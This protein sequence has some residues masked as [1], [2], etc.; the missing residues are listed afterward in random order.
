MMNLRSKKYNGGLEWFLMEYG[1]S[2]FN[3][4]LY[5]L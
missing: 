5:T 3:N 1:I 2:D 4:V